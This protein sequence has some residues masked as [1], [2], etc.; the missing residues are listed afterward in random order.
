MTL[1]ELMGK[2]SKLVIGL[3]GGTS[4]DGVDA[5]LVRIDNWGK[6]TKMEQLAYVSVPFEDE[7][8][9]RILDIAQGDFGGSREL[10]RMNMLLGELYLDACTRLCR[11]AGVEF[12]Q[13]DLIGSHGQTIYH[14]P[15]KEAYLGRELAATYQI[16]DVSVLCE[17]IGAPVVSDFRV[18]DMAAGGQGAP[19][20]PYTEYLLYRQEGKDVALQNIGG[21]GNMTFLPRS[22]ALSEL[23]AFDTGPGNVLIDGA[24]ERL[25]GGKLRYDAGGALAAAYPVSQALLDELMKDPYLRQKP[26]KTTG[27]EKYDRGFLEELYRKAAALSLS[28]GEVL[29]TVTRYTAETIAHAARTYLPRLPELLIIGGGGSYNLTLLEG[30]RELLPEVQVATNEDLGRDGDAK[31]AAAFALLAN[32][33]VHGICNNAPAATGASHP[34]VMG[35]ISQ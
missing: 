1:Q 27:R 28:D 15:V 32:E 11:R 7:V 33:A 25:S 29:A 3:M 8:R 17:K 23:I 4:A 35:K 31:E 20:V 2:R 9:Q 21:M 26:P 30:L 5:V 22:G 6:D 18:R 34:V 13:I 24:V 16:G 19:L 14:Q 10:G 12:S